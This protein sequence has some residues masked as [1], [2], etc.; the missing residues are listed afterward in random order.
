MNNLD[1][2]LMTD[3][4]S[5]LAAKAEK[6]SAQAQHI[7]G[8]MHV[9]PSITKAGPFSLGRGGIRG[10]FWTFSRRGLPKRRRPF[11]RY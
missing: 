4:F 8:R 6:G 10:E 3:D 1:S 7:P 11:G 2:A 5:A 9:S